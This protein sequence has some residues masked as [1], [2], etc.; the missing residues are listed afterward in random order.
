MKKT[1]LFLLLCL[2]VSGVLPAQVPQQRITLKMKQAPAEQVIDR[3]MADTRYKFSFSKEDLQQIPARDYAFENTPIEQVMDRLTED[4]PLSWSF[5]NGTIVI[6]RKK[7]PAKGPAPIVT[8]SGIVRDAEGRP[9]A[10]ATVLVKGQ[11]KGTTTN[12][13]GQFQLRVQQ[14]SV[15][16][17]SFLGLETKEL[18]VHNQDKFDIRLEPGSVAV[19]EVVVRTGYQTI[20]KEKMTGSAISLNAKDL[21]VS[22]SPNVTDNLE[23]RVA[24]LMTY[25][26]N[27]TI[28]GLSSLHASTSPLL[29]IDG[30]PVESKLED[31]NPYDIENI[32]VLKDAAATAIYGV[33]ASN[34]IIVVTTKQAKEQGSLTVDISANLTVYEKKNMNYADNFYLTPAQQVDLEAAY[35]DWYFFNS[36]GEIDNPT[37]TFANNIKNGYGISPVQYAY[38]QRA[39]GEI[40]QA[41]LDK[42][43]D[44]LR[45]NNF[46]K[47][48]GEE[49]LR[50]RMLQQYNIAL[51]S[52]GEK[53][54]SNLVFNFKHDNSG[55]RNAYDR[56]FNIFYK[57]AYNVTSWMKL[58]FGVNNIVNE[59]NS[60]NS[61][62]ATDPFNVPAY[63]RLMNDDGSLNYYTTSDYNPYDTLI[64]ETPELKSMLFNHVEEL[65]KDR[66]K[67]SWQ[68]TR[69]QAKLDFN[70]IKGLK[71]NTQF[72]YEIDRRS[73]SSY[74]EA[75]SYIMR[76][77]KNVY[78][79]REGSAPN[80]A[81]SYMLPQ[82]GGKLA[83]SHTDTDN[84]TVR[85]QADY[86]RTFG[87]HSVDVIAGLEFRETRIRGTRNLLL[88]YDE[89]N[90]SQATT[91]VS[92]PD[93][94]NYERPSFFMPTLPAKDQVY[95]K[96]L[97]APIGLV[98]EELHRYASG[99]FNATY[100]YDERY[101]AFA[102]FRKDY[103][104]IF[105]LAPKYRGKPLWSTGVGWNIHNE[106]FLRDVR[107]VNFLKLRV[108][109]GVTGNI[110]QGAT[111]FTTAN[112]TLYNEITKLPMAQ[113]EVPGNDK[114]KWERNV[115][116]NAG[117]DFA[118]FGNR[119]N[120][121]FDW[122]RK[123][124]KDIFHSMRVDCTSGYTSI[125]MNYADLKNDGF[126]INLSYD[127]FRPTRDRG[128][129]WSSSLTT[130][131]V[132][133]Q[134]TRVD[135]EAT[136]PYAMV[137][138]GLK[139]GYP[140]NGLFSL[141]YAGVEEENGKGVPAWHKADGTT[142]TESL[143][144]ADMSMVVYSGSED[145]KVNI[146]FSNT[147]RYKGFSLNFLL[148]YYGG[149]YLRA[150]QADGMPGLQYRAFA[151]YLK[152]S[153]TPENTDTLVPG[154]GQYSSQSTTGNMQ[155]ADAFVRPAAF[156][157]LRNVVVGYDLP[158]AFAR[159]LGMRNASIRFQIDN[160]KALW[161]K[162]SV[163]VD[164]ETGGIRQ[165]T[166]YIFGVNFNF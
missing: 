35:S 83:T 98:N 116:I 147:L 164:P 34:G 148:V 107:Q 54:Q 21:T 165:L 43:L 135:E 128:F 101:N 2:A 106:S 129:S 132:K 29:V 53:F 95:K 19:E 18:A 27:T 68:Y 143:T 89:Q 94:A 104:D 8:I 9:L 125:V 138:N 16:A 51:R 36:N 22:Y 62:F 44:E 64:E 30:L 113:I 118:F 7:V 1:L 48:Y 144:S 102:S 142:T 150:L 108:S 136:T 160:P 46:A 28:R 80:Y 155:Y 81:Y 32:T 124:G 84:W 41:Q 6:A 13:Q 114:L 122:Y 117:V 15:L 99:Y 78:T 105:G 42:Q 153:W 110:Y 37:G 96:Y 154:F 58:D 115:T 111:S 60:S 146:G 14:G 20:V 26:G 57:G 100:T 25:K 131:F 162:N 59:A 109:Y 103:A 24:G 159:K 130:T 123:T 74:S 69:Y 23:G 151:S 66:T 156:L 161:Q 39:T 90:Q 4:T 52:R 56:E 45:K 79:V 140:V 11:S 145:P 17:V 47:Q 65:G 157:K 88:G 134:I 126:E 119:L 76:Y 31:L 139:V 127:W 93:L 112:S 121:S 158:Q 166:S 85:L 137:S 61:D 12:G 163:G 82:S 71:F 133:N 73:T 149:H 97:E 55:I 67:N 86:S 33:R 40:D 92:F 141:P 10:G 72:I 87:K 38:Y 3:I 152:D 77:L 70:V 75:D 63:M 50:H 91:S 120:G 49:A 5:V